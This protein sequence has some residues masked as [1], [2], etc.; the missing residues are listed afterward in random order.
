MK[1][2]DKLIGSYIM[3]YGDEALG[4]VLGLKDIELNAL[5]EALPSDLAAALMDK[6]DN[7]QAVSCFSRLGKKNMTG[8]LGKLSYLQAEMI[9]RQLDKSLVDEL[10]TDLPEKL[11]KVLSQSLRYQRHQLGAYIDTMAFVLKDSMTIQQALNRMRKEKPELF[12]HVF[13]IDA[14]Q[15]V[16][17]S[18]DIKSICTQQESVKARNI[19]L[20]NVPTIKVNTDLSRVLLETDWGNYASLPVTNTRG[21]Y[22]GIISREVVW[23]LTKTGKKADPAL[24][25]TGYALGEL[26]NLGINGV[27]HS[28]T[29]PKSKTS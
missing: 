4:F 29:N 27:F 19:M 18:I 5:L 7:L 11:V 13:V 3:Q 24:S 16:V 28:M 1:N 10:L 2:D 9:L 23:N 14:N 26:F 22:L 21:V 12:S 25:Q 20:P 6:M 8:I 15:Q 17:G